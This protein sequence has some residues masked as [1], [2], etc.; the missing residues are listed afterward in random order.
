MTPTPE[1]LTLRA[2]VCDDAEASL[3]HDQSQFLAWRRSEATR[4]LRD[5]QKC[6]TSACLAGF[7]VL[8]LPLRGC[9]T[10]GARIW[11][12]SSPFLVLHIDAVAAEALGLDAGQASA[13]FFCPDETTAIARLRYTIDNPDVEYAALRKLIPEGMP[14]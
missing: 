2:Q 11:K 3:Y 5:L 4:P 13:I 8:R 1:Q 14:R 10:D 6:H 9:D 7:T 12:R